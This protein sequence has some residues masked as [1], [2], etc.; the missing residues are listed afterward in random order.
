MDRDSAITSTATYDMESTRLATTYAGRQ[1]TP[2]IGRVPLQAYFH[3]RC[4][5]LMLE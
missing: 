4:E 1:L 3:L 5:A 2:A